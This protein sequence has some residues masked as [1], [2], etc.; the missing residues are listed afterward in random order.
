M[1]GTFCNLYQHFVVERYISTENKKRI[2]E[3]LYNLKKN[4]ITELTGTDSPNHSKLGK[5]SYCSQV[6]DIC[7]LIMSFLFSRQAFPFQKSNG[8]KIL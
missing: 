4:I 3:D 1:L 7:S 2:G 5:P 8:L 6:F